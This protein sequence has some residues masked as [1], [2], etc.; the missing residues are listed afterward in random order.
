MAKNLERTSILIRAIVD[1]GNVLG[2]YHLNFGSVFRILKVYES[3]CLFRTCVGDLPLFV[4]LF[5]FFSIPFLLHIFAKR[6]FANDSENKEKWYKFNVIFVEEFEM[7]EETLEAECLG[8]TYKAA[9]Y[10]TGEYAVNSYPETRHRYWKG[11]MLF[12]E[13]SDKL[14]SQYGSAADGSGLVRHDIGLR[15]PPPSPSSSS[16]SS[17]SGPPSPIR[18]DGLNQLTALL[19]RGEKKAFSRKKCQLLS[20]EWLVHEFF[21]IVH[22]ENLQFMQNRDVYNVD[23]FR[24]VLNLASCNARSSS[25]DKLAILSVC[26]LQLAVQFLFNTYFRT[27]N[28]LRTQTEEWC[29]CVGAIVKNNSEACV[30]FVNFLAGERGKGYIRYVFFPFSSQHMFS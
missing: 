11:H 29:S 7:N 6:N 25:S 27:T 17:S 5:N 14:N 16:I 9:V 20:R 22:T 24:F 19:Q 12:Y 13:S 3:W 18:T 28:K 1:D 15:S 21:S 30:W 26:S 4:P 10:D 8:G 23:Y 2:L